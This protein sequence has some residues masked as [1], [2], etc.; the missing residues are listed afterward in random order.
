MSY[1][2]HNIITIV[3]EPVLCA[4]CYCK[5]FVYRYCF[6]YFKDERAEIREVTSFA[7]GHTA[8]VGGQARI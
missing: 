1:N 3:F 8:T 2:N 6:S 7:L 5:Q 4:S